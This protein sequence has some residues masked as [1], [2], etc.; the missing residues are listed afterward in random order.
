M[1]RGQCAHAIVELPKIGSTES[2]FLIFAEFETHVPFII[3]RIFVLHDVPEY[4][5]R[6]H[7]AHREQHQFI[8]MLSGGCTI[9][10]DNGTDRSRVCL[11]R[12]NIGLHVPP[13]HW[14]ELVE[15]KPGTICAVLSSG[16][17]EEEDYIRDRSQF[18]QM[19][20]R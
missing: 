11:D 8:M 2:G 10:I 5:E 4:A 6:G 18:D 9:I 1:D 16:I 14:L 7:H 17:Y 13:M 3:R 19:V 15:F 12:P 20:E